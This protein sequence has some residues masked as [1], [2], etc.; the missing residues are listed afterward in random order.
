M[1]RVVNQDLKDKIK[2]EQ[3][4]EFKKLAELKDALASNNS[5]ITK[6]KCRN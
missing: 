5:E 2:P 1:P 6:Q 4:E 3:V